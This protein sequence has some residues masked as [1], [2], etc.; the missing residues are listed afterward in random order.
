MS[1]GV[2]VVASRIGGIPEIVED[3]VSGLLAPNRAEDVAAAML[4]LQQDPPFAERL[5]ER[6]RLAVEERFSVAAMVAGT[7]RTYERALAC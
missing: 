5:A 4:R 6:A 3:G 1:A 2:P 7:I